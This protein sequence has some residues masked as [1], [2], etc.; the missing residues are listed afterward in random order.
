MDYTIKK[1]TELSTTFVHMHALC[2]KFVWYMVV[3]T[4]CFWYTLI[5]VTK[6]IVMS[7][8]PYK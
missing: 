2:M 4:M 8:K 7:T 5:I 6:L 1:Y 3:H